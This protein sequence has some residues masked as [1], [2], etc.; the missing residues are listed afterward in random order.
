MTVV[1][2]SRGGR[3][4]KG[5]RKFIGFR[6]SSVHAEKMAK[7]VHGE[8]MTVSDLLTDLVED[9]LETVD[10]NEIHQEALPIGRIAS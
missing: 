1:G 6:L 9:F 8:G 4:S 7:Y 10:V 3:R 2:H 5:D